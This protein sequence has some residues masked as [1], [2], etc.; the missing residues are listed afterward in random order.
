MLMGQG[1]VASDDVY[2]ALSRSQTI[3]YIWGS[4]CPNHGGGGFTALAAMSALRGLA[5]SCKNVDD[6]ALS[7]L[8]SFPAL[9]ACM[10]MDEPDVG[11]RHVGRCERLEELWQVLPRHGRRGD[12]AYRRLVLAEDLL[13]R[14][15]QGHRPQPG[16]P[17]THAV[18]RKDR[19]RGVR[20]DYQCGRRLAGRP[21]TFDS[22]HRRRIAQCHSQRDGGFSPRRSRELLVIAGDCGIALGIIRGSPDP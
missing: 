22:D 5:V 2:A 21:P 12:R 18:A 14:Q 15:D 9:R 7:A 10:P 19:V 8:P 4:E 16:D 13:R 20:G 1:A 3:E 17:W 11:F 6:T